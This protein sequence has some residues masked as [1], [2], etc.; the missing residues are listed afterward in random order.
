[1]STSL[2]GMLGRGKPP[3]IGTVNVLG[4]I[5]AIE[6]ACHAGFDFV[7]VD[8]Q[9][10]SFDRNLMREAVRAIDAAGCIAM[11]RPPAA[12]GVD[13]GSIEWLLDMGY[14]ALLMPMVNTADEARA[15]V[16]AAYYAPCGKRSVASCRANIHYGKEYRQTIN[17]ELV[18]LAMI[19]TVQAVQNAEQIAAIKGITGCFI[20]GGDL[21]V[22]MAGIDGEFDSKE[23]EQAIERVRQV[24]VAAG[25]VP[26]I[27]MNDPGG[28]RRR[29]E[30]GFELL[31]YA[32]DLRF[33]NGAL[34]H[35]HDEVRPV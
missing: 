6:L 31:T 19:E 11:A 32:T 34:N 25:K 27:A 29:I 8:W 20:G 12:V 23:F 3:V 17:N 28:V 16:E 4:S 14:R 21:G 1:M 22:D 10:G 18:V 33:M 2:R 24:T 26:A 30:Q 15:I 5:E 7:L 13:L 9:H 35:A